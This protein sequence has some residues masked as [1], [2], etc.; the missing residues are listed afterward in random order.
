VLQTWLRAHG[1]NHDV[2]IGVAWADSE[3]RAH[4]WL[5]VEAPSQSAGFHEISRVAP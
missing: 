1:R 4:A 3:F 5:D 2:V